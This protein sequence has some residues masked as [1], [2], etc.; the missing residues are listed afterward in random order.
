[1]PYQ[2]PLTCLKDAS[3]CFENG[4]LL[5]TMP[6]ILITKTSNGKGL[7]QNHVFHPLY[8]VAAA[9]VLKT[10][11]SGYKTLH[12]LIITVLKKTIAKHLIFICSLIQ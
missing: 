11:S 1:M 3:A 9:F 4:Q 10:F 6:R 8:H 7:K 12:V 2:A 5:Y